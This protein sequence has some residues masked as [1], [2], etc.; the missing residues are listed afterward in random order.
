MKSIDYFKPNVNMDL[1]F[2]EALRAAKENHVHIRAYDYQI[3]EEK[4]KIDQPVKVVF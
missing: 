3:K 1:N 2:A 4:I